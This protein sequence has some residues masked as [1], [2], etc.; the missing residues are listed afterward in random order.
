MILL[1]IMQENITKMKIEKYISLRML[2]ISLIFHK[3]VII[4]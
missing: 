4:D 3:L 1:S 2:L